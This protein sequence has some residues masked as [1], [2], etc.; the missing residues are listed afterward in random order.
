MKWAY[1][2]CQMENKG[3]GVGACLPEREGFLEKVGIMALLLG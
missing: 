1:S 3:N 2:L